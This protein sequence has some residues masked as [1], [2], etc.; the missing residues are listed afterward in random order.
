MNLLSI[1]ESPL[2][3]NFASLYAELGIIETRVDSMRKA[4]KEAKRNP[5]DF[6]VAE[7]VYGWGNNYAGVNLSNLDVLLYALEKFAPETRV[8]VFADKDERPHVDKL[9]DIFPLHGV[10]VNPPRIADMRALLTTA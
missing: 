3:P 5:P 7:F 9:L 4:M 8:I 6:V 1:V 10:L 2:H